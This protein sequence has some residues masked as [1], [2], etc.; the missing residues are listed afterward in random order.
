MADNNSNGSLSL[1]GANQQSPVA[2]TSG[3][4]KPGLNKKEVTPQTEK[5]HTS[6]NAEAT[7]ANQG[8]NSD[9]SYAEI[10]TGLSR[11]NG[12]G[13]QEMLE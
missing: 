4:S 1:A 3:P 9:A 7:I 6:L 13:F 11:N 10:I 12:L 5:A 8:M 2:G